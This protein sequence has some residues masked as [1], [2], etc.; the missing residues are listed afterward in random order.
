MSATHLKHVLAVKQLYR[1]ILQ[2]HRHMPPAMRVMGDM[3]VRDEFKRHKGA[4]AS[5]A[6]VFMAEWKGYAKTLQA[7]LGVADSPSSGSGDAATPI[8][9][10]GKTDE[11]AL[12]TLGVAMDP[13]LLDAMTDEQVGQLHELFVE[14]RQSPA[15]SPASSTSATA[16]NTSA[17][18]STKAATAAAKASVAPHII[19]RVTRKQP[20]S[21][22]NSSPR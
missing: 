7:Q 3:Y 2:L 6:Q 20:A 15:A 17:S 11:P 13:K 9:S 12:G 10:T 1:Q 18:E 8:S 19:A 21:N 22:A 14:A 16:S 4:Q 5:Q